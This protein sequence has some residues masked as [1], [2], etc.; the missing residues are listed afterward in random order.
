MLGALVKAEPHIEP[1]VV[2]LAREVVH[3]CAVVVPAPSVHVGPVPYAQ[4]DPVGSK[5]EPV[6]VGLG[7]VGAGAAHVECMFF[8]FLLVVDKDIIKKSL[9][10]ISAQLVLKKKTK[11]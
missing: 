9:K 6:E 10:I 3:A 4:E 5:D 7:G 11:P 2:E 8:F 1:A